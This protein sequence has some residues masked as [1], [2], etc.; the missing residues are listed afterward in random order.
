MAV[1]RILLS[2][3]LVMILSLMACGGGA[4]VEEDQE[5]LA[6]PPEC[7]PIDIP[8]IPLYEPL[9]LDTAANI[10]HIPREYT[11]IQEGI[12]T[13]ADGDAVLVAPGTYYENIDFRGKGI[14]ITSEA[15]PDDTIID[16]GRVTSVVTFW[17][18]EG[19]NSVLHGF[20]ITNGL[21]EASLPF[22]GGISIRDASPKIS[23]CK[24]TKN[25]SEGAAGGIYVGGKPS[26]T[27]N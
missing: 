13:A 4:P 23:Y 16:G 18:G 8:A 11:T 2:L 19:T 21:V 20:T 9:S 5:T 15:G 3:F 1:I 14:T 27:C 26:S 6:L 7:P 10:I 22:G 25:G 12:D 24:I 17:S